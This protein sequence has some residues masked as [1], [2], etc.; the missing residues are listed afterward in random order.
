MRYVIAVTACLAVGLSACGSY[1]PTRYDKGTFETASNAGPIDRG[2]EFL[3]QVRN[4]EIEAEKLRAGEPKKK[5]PKL[6]KNQKDE[7][8]EKD[9]GA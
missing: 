5:P 9:N 2:T 6:F 3:R 1:N 4:A 7:D 8:D